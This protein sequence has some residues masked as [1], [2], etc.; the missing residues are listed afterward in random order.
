MRAINFCRSRSSFA[1]RAALALALL[2]VAASGSVAQNAQQPVNTQNAPP[3]PPEVRQ[4]PLAG[5]GAISTAVEL[6]EVDV[7]ITDRDGKPVKGL[8]QD[9]FSVSE[10]GHPQKL[11]SFDF[12]DVE[13]VETAQNSESAPV[14]VA[15]GAVE[16]PEKLREVVRDRRLIVLF[17][18]LSSLQ[19]QDLVRTTNAAKRFLK[20]QMTPADLVGVM[21]FGNQLHVLS[22]FTT[23]RDQLNRAV[24]SVVPGKE[25]QL[26]G[27][28]DASATGVETAVSEDT[29]A[30]FSADETEFNIF[31]TDRKLAAL[32]SVTALLGDIPGK[33]SVIQFTS[34]ITQT[35]EDNRSQLRVTTDAANRANVAIYTVD[36]RGLLAEIPGGDASVGAAS[37]KSLFTGDAVYK[38]SDSREDSRE[39]LSTLA[40]DTGGRSFFD[41]GDL[42][43][44]FSAVQADTAGY[45]LLGYYSTN[46]A[47]DG[48]WRAIRVRV[49]G[50]PSGARLRYRE[51]YYAPKNFG[52]FT[53]EDRERQLQEAMT[54]DTPVVELPIA[55]ETAHFDL[56]PNQIFVPV[57]AK[58]SSSALQWARKSNRQQVEFDFVV[59]ARNAQSK[60]VAA[61]LRDTITVRLGDERFQQVQQNDL[62]YQ[63]GLI[64]PPGDYDL[65]FLARE[66]ETGRVGTFDQ[67]LNLPAP[68]PTRLQLSSIVLSNQLVMD[69]KSSE[70]QTK[71]LAPDAKLK[72]TPLDVAGQRIIPSVTRVFTNNQTLYVFFQ[73]YVPEKADPN[74]LRAGIELFRDGE[75]VSQT[76]MLQPTEVGDKGRIASFRMNLPLADVTA[77]R[78]TIEAVVVEPGGTQ[79]A[80]GRNYFALRPATP[81]ATPAPAPAPGAGN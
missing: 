18:D 51:G 54:S 68:S 47:H 24:D 58:L 73:A 44:A 8:K 10:D 16:T 49:N 32:E 78:Y 34:G 27:L 81:A 11:S 53:T 38:Q 56:S 42:G 61:A 33:K 1:S 69:Q 31:N 60:R 50:M 2:G 71:G 6:V 20:E 46:P 48:R 4:A 41:L 9:Q 7:E 35:G 62:V 65:K 59:E 55:V 13:R 12:N 63:G 15:I 23:D 5:K 72:Q 80:F 79:A 52:I 25:S 57:S 21:A 19:P 76:P 45:Y 40:S 14:T 3:P 70:V 43:Q 74:Q 22:D 17:F 67:E 37:G 26:A 39:T 66:N 77:G 64:L 29:D 28:A 36:S 75:R 30:A